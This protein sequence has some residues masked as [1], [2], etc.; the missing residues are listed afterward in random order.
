[1]KRWELARQQGAKWQVLLIQDAETDLKIMLLEAVKRAE[2]Y[3]QT[4]RKVRELIQEVVDTLDIDSMK[5]MARTSLTLYADR[6]YIAWVN[7]YGTKGL[8]T[9]LVALLT[10]K[11]IR[12]PKKEQERL[13]NLPNAVIESTP[14]LPIGNGNKATPNGI[15]N[16]EYEREV[17]RRVNSV[18]DTSAKEDYSERYSLRASV[19]RELRYEHNRRQIESRRERG[20]RLVWIDSHANCSERCAPFQGR[21]YSLTGES[22][23]EDGIPYVPLEEATDIYE[24]T[25]SGRVWKNGC[26]SGFNCRHKLVDYKKGFRPIKI[27]Q[28]VIDRER[29]IDSQ[30]RKYERTIRMY[31]TRAL[32]WKA[33]DRL[34]LYRRYRAKAKEWTDR[35]IAFAR[36]NKVAFYP[37]RLDI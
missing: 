13:I 32:G 15:Y 33:N 7:I 29:N 11:G 12:I 26:V 18:L 21:L 24:T 6:M 27:P 14:H 16:L 8:G 25:R 22:G 10:A 31:E 1:M 4:Q 5:D 17:I 2:P 34:D 28:E 20:V 19:E 9:T 35:Y 23:K 37:S 30:L 36:E 3:V